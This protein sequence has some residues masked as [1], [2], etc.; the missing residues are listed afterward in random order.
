SS[1]TDQ[2]KKRIFD[3]NVRHAA[4]APWLK[5]QQVVS[6]L[7]ARLAV[8]DDAVSLENFSGKLGAAPVKGNLSLSRQGEQ[9]LTGNIE[10]DA[11]DVQ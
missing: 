1:V 10:T 3:L 2:P 5:P 11:L 8:S 6:H 7:S 4:L 9:T